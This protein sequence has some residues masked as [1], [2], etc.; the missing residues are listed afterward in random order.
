MAGDGINDAPALAA[1]TVGVAIAR[2]P[3]DMVASAADII[4]LNGQ[5]VTN[6]PWL[7][8]VAERTDTILKQVGVGTA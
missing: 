2:S 7:F 4:I 8:H 1:S 3:T 5:G 6:L